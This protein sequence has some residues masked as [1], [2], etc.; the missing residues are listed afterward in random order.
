MLSS[1][2]EETA[3]PLRISRLSGAMALSF[4]F[5]RRGAEATRLVTS[6]AAVRAAVIAAGLGDET[7]IQRFWLRL[8]YT[9]TLAR[10]GVV[11]KD[12]EVFG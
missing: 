6:A 10:C 12:K 1:S 4:A 7:G 3:L 9:N 8:Q 2:A 11:G 5:W